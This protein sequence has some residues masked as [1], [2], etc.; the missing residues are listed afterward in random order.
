MKRMK[1]SH[2]SPLLSTRIAT[3]PLGLPRPNVTV[4]SDVLRQPSSSLS[5]RPVMTPL[6]HTSSSASTLA[7]SKR[8]VAVP[9]LPSR[10][11]VS[12]TSGTCAS[13]A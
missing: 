2:S 12:A 11:R 7:F 10:E 4:T 1:R 6:L 8:N 3:T 9:V 5:Q 13:G